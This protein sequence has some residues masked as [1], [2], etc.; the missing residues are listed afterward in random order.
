MQDLK[1]KLAEVQARGEALQ[2]SNAQL[3]NRLEA[4]KLELVKIC[5][6]IALLNE[7]LGEEDDNADKDNN[8]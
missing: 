3:I 8:R 1:D 6:Q 2:Q 7:L 4:N 5:G